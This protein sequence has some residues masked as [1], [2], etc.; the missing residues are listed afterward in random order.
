VKHGLQ[1][2]KIGFPEKGRR[3]IG[4]RADDDSERD[5]RSSEGTRESSIFRFHPILVTSGS[6]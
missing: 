4:E 3:H 1:N 6:W 5:P 2:L